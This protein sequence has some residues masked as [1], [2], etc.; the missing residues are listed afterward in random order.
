MD[1]MHFL[2][3]LVITLV[4]IYLIGAL[5][6]RTFRIFWVGLMIIVAVGLF[7]ALLVFAFL[8]PQ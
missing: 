2:F 5:P 8:H 6:W 7:G 3:W 4:A 1:A